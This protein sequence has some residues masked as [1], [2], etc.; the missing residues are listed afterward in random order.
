MVSMRRGNH[1][2]GHVNVELE[3]V[4]SFRVC[5]KASTDGIEPKKRSEIPN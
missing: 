2:K 4:L 1:G 5:C 3:N